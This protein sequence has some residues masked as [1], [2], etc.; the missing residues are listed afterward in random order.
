[1][2]S[3]RIAMN[4]VPRGDSSHLYACAT[5]TSNC[6]RGEREPADCLRRVDDG[7]RTVL[8]SGGRDTVEVGDLSRR[9]LHGA[10]GDDVDVR[11]DLGNELGGR[12]E[13]NGDAAVLLHEEREEERGELDVGHEHPR[14]VRNRG[15][16]EADERRDV[17][18]DGDR[19]DGNADEPGERRAR[20][21]AGDAPV[22]PARP[23]SLPVVERR[24]E[25][26]PGRRRREAVRR[27]VQV[28]ARRRPERLGVVER[29]LLH[30]GSLTRRR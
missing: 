8:G 6:V 20:L 10:E 16:D 29:Q 24:L 11:A 12:N 23:A 14:A 15:R 19:L 3:G 27:G 28:R 9:H 22:L 13:P 7:Q 1:M 18:A 17:R 4:A 2:R 21:F 26:V 30:E 5:T 25:R